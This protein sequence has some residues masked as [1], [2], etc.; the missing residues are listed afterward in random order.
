MRC[1]R[2]LFTRH[3]RI[4]TRRGRNARYKTGDP[5]KSAGDKASLESAAL[6]RK[7]AEPM[8]TH[9]HPAGTTRP[10]FGT[11]SSANAAPRIET[12]WTRFLYRDLDAPWRDMDASSHE[13]RSHAMHERGD[14]RPAFAPRTPARAGALLLGF[15]VLLYLAVAGFMRLVAHDEALVANPA[16][17]PADRPESASMPPRDAVPPSP[18]FA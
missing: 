3:R 2:A 7:E 9:A 4:G 15:Y 6:E 5:L 11:T 12:H 8:P 16:V 18:R 13:R 10:A 1:V 14:E 17:G